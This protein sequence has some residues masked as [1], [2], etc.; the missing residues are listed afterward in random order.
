MNYKT[1]ND[2]PD[3]NG[4]PVVVRLDL[5]VPVQNGVVMADYRIRKALPTIQFLKKKGAKII[6]L[7]HIEGGTDSLMPVYEFMKKSM[8]LSFCNDCLEQGAQVVAAMK[9]GDVL[10]CENLRLY[11]G[12]KKNDPAF[13]KSLAALGKIYV[14]DGFSVSHRN[15]ASI[16][17]IPTFIPGYIG[18]QFEDEIKNLSKAFSPQHP[19]VFILGGA[20][21]E[22][23]IPLI[24]KFLPTAD[25]III[26]GA[27]AND[28]FKAS[29]WNVG[30]SLVSPTPPDMTVYVES[31]KILTPSDVIVEKPDGSRA[32]KEATHVA[33][34]EKICDAGPQ[35]I[36]FMKTIVAQA[37]CI[38]WNGP[39]GNYENGY[40]EP[41]LKLAEMIA[42]SSALSIVGG[43]D[44]LGA[45][46]ELG[47]EEKFGFVSTG[48][49]AMLDYLASETLPG[50]DALKNS[51]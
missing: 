20:K 23:K 5:N 13:A 30:T 38:L 37:S 42:E 27:L 36:K 50:L 43:G 40:K 41:T 18:L 29:G 11:D 19:F 6:I 15:H 35:S 16:V 51:K 9:A 3:V 22:T 12:E 25:S 39:L 32:I 14:N 2:L 45:I 4:V 49:G 7:S 8:E 28:I 34:D 47:I 1:L 17:G 26:G 48:G 31:D 33:H 21:F 24:D 46:A 10:L 44:T